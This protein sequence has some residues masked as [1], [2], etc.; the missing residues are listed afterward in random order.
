MGALSQGRRIFYMVK[1]RNF[2]GRQWSTRLVIVIDLRRVNLIGR[3]TRLYFV[4][5]QTYIIYF[6]EDVDENN[7]AYSALV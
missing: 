5:P 7:V 3:I 6:R 1:L 2:Q 4:E